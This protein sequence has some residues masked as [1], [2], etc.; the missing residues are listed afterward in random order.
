MDALTR[1]L[2]TKS[3]K[4]R[5][6]DEAGYMRGDI[7]RFLGIRYQH[8]RNVLVAPGPSR[9]STGDPAVAAALPDEPAPSQDNETT[10][11]SKD[12]AP[13][14]VWAKIG[15]DGDIRIPKSFREVLALSPGD[16]VILR[17]EGEVLQVASRDAAIRQARKI[18]R[19]F[20]PEGVSL[21]D[22]LIADRRAEA[23]RENR[24]D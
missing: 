14:S 17:R 6:L 23:A 11:N 22:E 5:A 8:V 16:D 15:P 12:D 9:E 13:R 1:D 24:G 18:A 19:R 10:A 21:V 4:I 3:S 20:V 7:G 2:T